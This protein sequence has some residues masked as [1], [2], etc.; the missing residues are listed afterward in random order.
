VQ[1][2]RNG[3]N[4]KDFPFCAQGHQYALDIL[5][6]EIA[7]CVY[8]KGACERYLKDL[9]R[10]DIFMDWERAERYLRL[11]QKFPHVK[12]NWKTENVTFL[13]WQHFVWM[14]IM[15][16]MSKITGQRRFRIA[17]VE[18]SRG[19]SKSTMA[20][21]AVL[22]FLALDNPKGN[23]ISTVA[24]RKEQAR[25]VL[26]AAR[27]MARKAEGYRT[28]TG[29]KVQAHAI[30]HEKSN[31][32]ARALS[33]DASGLDGLQ[34]ILAVCDELH[35]MNRETFEV[36]TSGMSK[37]TDSLTLCITTAGFDIDSVGYSQSIYAKKVS[38]GETEDDQMFSIVYTLDE[39]DD[40]FDPK[41]WI[42]A[43]PGYGD[44]VDPYTFEAKA[45]K[46]QEMPSDIPNFKVKHLNIWLSEANAYFDMSKWNYCYDPNIKLEDFKGQ[47][48]VVGVDLA[49]KID[50]TS[51]G[52]IFKKD[53]IYYLFD[54]SYIPEATVREVRNTL[55]DDCI[56]RG[57]LIQTKG[58]AINYDELKRQ[59]IA[60]SKYFDI[61]EVPYDP[62]SAT[63]FAQELCNERIEMTEFRFNTANLSEPTKNMNALL[64]QKRIRHNG[65][66]L[67][68]WAFSN[69]VCK[70]DAADNIF[71]KKTHDRL[72]IDPAIALIMALAV[73][74]QQE[75]KVSVY[76]ERGIRFL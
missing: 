43:N 3:P 48:C 71:P 40:I 18:V 35:A 28:N 52:Y 61:I 20:S 8:V 16:W 72:K 33:A 38:L 41:N 21:M 54:R 67:L 2:K 58:E 56:A 29:V 46:A 70:I 7:S 1:K 49:S 73:W 64:K 13:P 39:K 59:I 36:I 51:F 23:E 45:K 30:L 60:D 69:I 22:Y 63:H 25:I 5:S 9:D 26:D 55:Y 37:R 50:I 34:D 24:S 76:N 65:S 66:P 27:A 44:S 75:N 6:G 42:K 31:S 15:G 57:H 68:K 10:N 12:G 53:D 19:N 14:N 74:M 47:R 17:H 4:K 11:V 32:K 62:W